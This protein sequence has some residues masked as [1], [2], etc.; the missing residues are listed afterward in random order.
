MFLCQCS[1]AFPPVSLSRS[2]WSLFH[3]LSLWKDPLDPDLHPASWLPLFPWSFSFS[4]RECTKRRTFK[5]VLLLICHPRPWESGTEIVRFSVRK[6]WGKSRA[7]L[8]P[9]TEVFQQRGR[10]WCSSISDCHNPCSQQN[11]TSNGNAHVPLSHAWLR[12]FA[13]RCFESPQFVS[14]F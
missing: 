13:R 5:L 4:K 12:S 2:M 3:F 10:C 9:E 14:Y 7:L 11:H 1:C 6:H 8:S